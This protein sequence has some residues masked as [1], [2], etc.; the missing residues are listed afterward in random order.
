MLKPIKPIM[1]KILKGII[2]FLILILKNDSFIFMESEDEFLSNEE[3]IKKIEENVNSSES[4][5]DFLYKHKIKILISVT[6]FTLLLGVFLVTELDKI[7]WDLESLIKDPKFFHYIKMTIR[8]LDLDDSS[9]NKELTFKILRKLLKDTHN[10]EN[11]Q[12]P[13]KFQ[14]LIEKLI[15]ELKKDRK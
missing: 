5:L 8:H 7:L 12:D 13:E 14:K 4:W 2:F 10:N 6:F 3:N 11:I 15:E 9:E 1:Q